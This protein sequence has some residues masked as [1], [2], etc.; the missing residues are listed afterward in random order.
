MCFAY[1]WIPVSCQDCPGFQ[2]GF[3]E[4]CDAFSRCNVDGD[5]LLRL[6]DSEL[7]A[8]IGIGCAVTRKRYPR[9]FVCLSVCDKPHKSGEFLN[10]RALRQHSWSVEWSTGWVDNFML[11]DLLLSLLWHLS[12][13]ASSAR[14][15]CGRCTDSSDV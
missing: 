13:I 1:D 11:T 9:L 15:T 8:S 6:T 12:I 4:Y 3:E 2:V 14:S 7:N 5:L 10:A